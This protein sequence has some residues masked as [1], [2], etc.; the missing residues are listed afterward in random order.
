MKTNKRIVLLIV[1]LFVSIVSL[2]AN[3]RIVDYKINVNVNENYVLNVKEDY[4]FEFDTPRH[5]FYRVIPYQNYPNHNIKI[6]NIRVKGG[7]YRT[8]RSGGLLTIRVGDPDETVLGKVNYSIS[9]DYDIGVDT[10]A[11]F[12]EFYF[13]LIGTM[14]DCEINNASF[15]VNFPKPIDKDKVWLTVGSANTDK[16]NNSLINISS[17]LK[18]I[19]GN[20]KN[21]DAREGATLRSEFEDGYFV[22]ARDYKKTINLMKFVLAIGNILLM[23]LGFIIFSKHGRD[24]KLIEQSRFDAPNGFT[25]LSLDYFL[26]GFF[27]SKAYSASFIYWA[28]QG[29]IDI[30]QYDDDNIVLI[31]KVDFLEIKQH[32]KNDLD[33][34]LFTAIFRGT[35]IGDEVNLENIDSEDLGTSLNKLK[36]AGERKFDSRLLN[37]SKAAK[38]RVLILLFA[39]ISA[40]LSFLF[41]YSVSSIFMPLGLVGSF[42]YIV[43]A[44]ILLAPI[45][46]KWALFKWPKR[47]FIIL[48]TAILTVLYGLMNFIN[49]YL[50]NLVDFKVNLF[51]SVISAI[52]MLA[53]ILLFCLTEKRS[54]FTQ[55]VLEQL[56]GYISF[57]KLVE[58][59]QIEKMIEDNPQLYFKHLSYAQVLDLTKTWEHKFA[60]F[61]ITQPSWYIAPTYGFY[62]YHR[63]NT[64]SNS[65][66]KSLNVPLAEYAKAHSSHSSSGSSFSGFSGSVGGGAGGG[67]GGAW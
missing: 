28:D 27:S 65:L 40:G 49:V 5:G 56:L 43:F 25:P 24:Q 51:V 6:R 34:K 67:G 36:K 39:F 20:I 47:F 18:S 62:S 13:N 15:V 10:Y 61:E 35:N 53:L 44:I 50:L 3:Y 21:L 4:V 31:R 22:G 37:D 48:A 30:K 55:T 42:F 46:S 33:Y 1:S 45:N 23:L 2:F 9:Y 60:N 41:T 26:N 38:M 14:W 59:D 66:N 11:D 58:V 63:I 16:V 8:E 29:Y 54:V 17:D 7:D 57:L 12:D 32:K 64:I 52:S 19:S